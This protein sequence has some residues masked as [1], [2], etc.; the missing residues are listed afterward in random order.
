MEVRRLDQ[1]LGL[2]LQ[3]HNVTAVQHVRPQRSC[4]TSILDDDIRIV[5][6]TVEQV[7]FYSP[8]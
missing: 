8:F 7:T 2:W 3:G 5:H 1:E 4:A 6:R